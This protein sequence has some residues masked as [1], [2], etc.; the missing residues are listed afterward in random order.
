M[1]VCV[2]V[3]ARARVS[4][5]TYMQVCVSHVLAV[6]WN[7]DF[8]MPVLS[9]IVLDRLHP[10]P[11]VTLPYMQPL[12]PDRERWPFRIKHMLKHNLAR[13]D[14]HMQQVP[15]SVEMPFSSHEFLILS[16]NAARQPF[17]GQEAAILVQSVSAALRSCVSQWPSDETG[18]PLK[19]LTDR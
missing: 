16:I 12:P 9:L 18:V 10:L 1:S 3:C 17:Q 15:S 4:V 19:W 7:L 11:L 14:G 6:G 2:C 13:T 8:V 5:C